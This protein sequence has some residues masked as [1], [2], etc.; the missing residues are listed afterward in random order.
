MER[1]TAREVRRL[2]ILSLALVLDSL[3]FPIKAFS[4]TIPFFVTN[5]S[6]TTELIACDGPWERCG[7]FV[8]LKPGQQRFNFYS[9]EKNIFSP[10]GPWT[11][12][13]GPDLSCPLDNQ[14][15]KISSIIN[16]CLEAIPGNPD[17]GVEITVNPNSSMSVN[18]NRNC[19]SISVTAHLGDDSKPSAPDRDAF[20]FQGT[21]GD[22]VTLRL[23]EDTSAGY[24]GEQA[25]LI[26][27]DVI[28]EA[29]LNEVITG[30]VPFE[31]KTTLP[32]TGEYMILV[33]QHN[34][35]LDARFRGN[36]NLSLSTSGSVELLV[37]ADNV[38]K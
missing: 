26:L 14:N 28:S 10:F 24:I 35:P 8:H 12:A 31:I 23:E 11:C 7:G 9:A 5:N 1:M 34:I 6:N 16:F 2:A 4:D 37:P 21:Q 20:S 30:A 18:F 19:S 13:V 15:N 3:F 33:Q 25:T 17:L 36:Y 38:E 32:A 27:R 22:E 29:S